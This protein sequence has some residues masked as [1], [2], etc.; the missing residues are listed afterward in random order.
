[1]RKLRL[2]LTGGT[3]FVG[4]NIVDAL[5]KEETNVEIGLLIRDSSKLP[6]FKLTENSQIKVY[7]GDI[8]NQES[9]ENA[10]NFNPTAVI[11]AAALVDDWA[12]LNKLMEVNVQGTQNLINAIVSK[13]SSC[14]LVHVSSTGVYPRITSVITEETSLSPFEKYHQSKLESEKVVINA[15]INNS[16]AATILRPPNVMGLR[17]TTHMAKICQA[18]QEGKFPLINSGKAL[19]TWLGGEDLAQATILALRHRE[20]AA[21]KIYNLKSFEI[22]VKNL[23][24]LIANKLK[25]SVAPKNYNYYLAYSIGVISEIIGKLRSKPS[26]L[27]RYRVLKFA[28]DRQFDDSLIREELGYL[29]KCTAEETI[30]KTVDWLLDAGIVREN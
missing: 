29:P 13:A 1:V 26:T 9:L 17:D 19:Q 10:M 15:V 11:H 2:L 25:V 5:L 23:Y 12:P 4:S 30:L 16:L 20:I 3:G 27:N 14:F 8:T 18:I 28:R 24:D 21:G 22:S 7:T 6:Q